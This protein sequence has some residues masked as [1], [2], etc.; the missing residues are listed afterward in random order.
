MKH[1]YKIK[2]YYSDTDSYGV[3]WHGAY[4]KW[5][6]VGRVE[7]A[8]LCGVSIEKL[9]N[10]NVGL[11]V[12][13]MNIRYKRSAKLFDELIIETSLEEL[14]NTRISFAHKISDTNTNQLILNATTT[15][16]AID[17]QGKLIKKMPEYIYDNF[18]KVIENAR[19]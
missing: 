10:K 19:L 5:L 14:R 3:V 15:V 12:V 4:V 18:K 16:V 17:K 11:P 7:F 13:E 2:V 6:E 9:E 1:D 8:N